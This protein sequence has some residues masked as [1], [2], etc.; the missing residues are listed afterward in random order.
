MRLSVI[1]W[2]QP[3]FDYHKDEYNKS[4]LF[5]SRRLGSLFG[6]RM[7]NSGRCKPSR[8]RTCPVWCGMNRAYLFKSEVDTVLGYA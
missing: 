6:K 4:F 7:G 5:A 1:V 3:R 2:E 8:C